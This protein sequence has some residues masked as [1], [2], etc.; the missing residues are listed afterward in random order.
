LRDR[1][2]HREAD[3]M[4]KIFGL[5]LVVLGAWVGLELYTEGPSHAFGGAFASIL[6]SESPAGEEER[7][8]TPQRAGS[9]VDR[10]HRE[11]EARFDRMLA[12]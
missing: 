7:L 5:L 3:I 12:D 4:A 1:T 11:N 2:S 9:A 8:S 10:A 6:G